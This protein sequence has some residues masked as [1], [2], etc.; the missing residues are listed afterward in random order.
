MGD[1]YYLQTDDN[2]LADG[3]NWQVIIGDGGSTTDLDSTVSQSTTENDLG[4]TTNGIGRTNWDGTFQ[5]VLDVS[6]GDMA[7]DVDVKVGRCNAAGTLQE[8][9]GSDGG[10]QT[11]T[12]AGTYTWN[13]TSLNF[14]TALQTDRLRINLAIENT[15]SMGDKVV[16]FDTN[17]LSWIETPWTS[18]EF[19]CEVGPGQTDYSTFSAW[20]AGVACDL[21]DPV[22]TRVFSGTLTAGTIPDN[23]TVSGEMSLATGTCV[24]VT[25]TQIL[26]DNISAT[27]FE[28]GEKVLND[29]D[30]DQ[31][32][33][34]S[35]AGAP[36]ISVAELANTSTT[37]DTTAVDINWSGGTNDRNYFIAR[38]AS[39]HEATPPYTTSKYH[40]S[41]TGYPLKVNEFGFVEGVQFEGKGGSFYKT[42]R[43]NGAN[44]LNSRSGTVGFSGVLVKGNIGA[45]TSH[46]GIE[47]SFATG[48]HLKG[49]I[50]NS[51]FY[52]F[53]NATCSA[54]EVD[55]NWHAYFSNN[56]IH[57]CT[58]GFFQGGGGSTRSFKNNIFHD[59]S[60]PLED[61]ITVASH[62][63]V[64]ITPDS[65]VAV[66]ST[67]STGATTGTTAS[68]VVDSSATFETDGVQ[69]G[70]IVKNTTDT[71]YTYVT[72]IDSQTQLSVND[73]IFVSGENYSVFTNLYG[74][75]TFENE[76]T[77]DF[78]LGS[79]DTAARG[80][81]TDLSSDADL[82]VTDDIDGD[83]RSAWDVGAD[84]YTASGTSVS[85][86][87][88]GPAP[89]A[90]GTAKAKRKASG[91][92]VGP[93][94]TATGTATRK[95]SVSG[96]GVGPATT[97]SG[98]AKA[99][100]KASG[101]G[102][103]PA[104]T[105]S[106]TVTAAAAKECSGTGIGPAPT[107]SGTVAPRE[108]SV[109]GTGLG[110][111]P[112]ATG[113]AV[114]KVSVTGTGAGPA[115]TASG[116]TTRK[117]SVSGAGIG[118]AP[119]ATGTG[120]HGA[121]SVSGTGIGPA[122]TA[123]GTV[124]PRSIS[125]SGTGVGPTPTAVGAVTGGTPCSGTGVGPAPTATGTAQA[126]RNAAGT[127]AGPAATAS[128][129]A[130]RALSVSGTGVGPAPTAAGTADK[131]MT[132]SGTATGPAPTATG[133]AS[134][135]ALSSGSGT[136]P[137]PTA[138]GTA[139][140][141]VPTT[142]TGIGPAPTASGTAKAKRKAS[143]TGL[144][145]AP[146]AA[147]VVGV[148]Y[149]VDATG[150][151]DGDDGTTEET[152]W[153]T[154]SFLEAQ[155]IPAGATIRLKRGEIWRENLNPTWS[156]SS[157]NPILVEDYGSGDKPSLRGSYIYTSGW[158]D[159][160]GN[161]WRSTASIGTNP[162]VVLH[163]EVLGDRKED[164]VDMVEQWDYWYGTDGGSPA[165]IWIY[166]TAD[167]STMASMIEYGALQHII[168]LQQTDY[169]TYR[170]LDIRQSYRT[171]AGLWGATNIR[172]EDC[173]FRQTAGNCIQFHNGS[174]DGVVT[175]C[176]FDEWNV[177]DT[178]SYAVHVTGLG[179]AD[180]GP[181]DITYCSFTASRAQTPWSASQPPP[182]KDHSCVMGDDGGWVRTF[183]NNTIDG[184]NGNLAR[185]GVTF[186]KPYSSAT[187]YTCEDN[188]IT[189]CG[190]AGINLGQV[191]FNSLASMTIRVRRNIVTDSCLSDGTATAAMR[192]RDVPTDSGWDVEVSY[193]VVNGT[194][195]GNYH[196]GIEL[197]GS[198]DVKVYNNTITGTD[199]GIKLWDTSLN[200]DIQNNISYLNRTY[201][202]NKVSGSTIATC[203][204]NCFSG[205]I[206]ADY[207][208]V[209]PGSKDTTHD[210][211]LDGELKPQVPSTCIDGGTDVGLSQDIIG[212]AV[213]QGSAEDM[214]AYEFRPGEAVSGSGTGPAPTAT[215]TATRTVPVSGT[216]V[217]AAPAAT[218]TVT[219][220][221]EV[222]G[223]GAGASPTATGTATR[224]VSVT[225]TGVGPAPSASGTAVATR[226]CSGA[227]V[228]P[229]PAASGTAT[230]Q[231]SVTGTGVGAAP[232]ATGTIAARALSAS[233][234]G[235]G[236]A[237]TAAGTVLQIVSG[238][239]TAIGPAPTA[240]GT[241]TRTV[242]GSGAGT[243]PA[244][245]ASGVVIHKA[246]A[247]G[248]AV[249]PAPAATGTA[250]RVVSVSGT[251]AGPAPVA[252]GT[253]TRQVSVAGTGV[254]PAP[255][256][257]GWA[258]FQ[259][260]VSGAGVGPAPTAS[261]SVVWFSGQGADHT[262]DSRIEKAVDV[263]SRVG[264]ELTVDSRAV[265]DYEVESPTQE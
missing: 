234:T 142:G 245:A 109:S 150:G 263:D 80:K 122:P 67:H 45:A 152:A 101:T 252:V 74:D 28:S 98:T 85:G 42:L 93:A 46:S 11:V 161:L 148:I 246:L 198:D 258:G 218:G 262:V 173:D 103:G 141:A 64:F 76:G 202:I 49:W 51:V 264:K 195:D 256:A 219:R 33:T 65:T 73:D 48:G 240:S 44:G 87:G 13:F 106:G 41:V 163:D 26:I 123:T 83:T 118:P 68:K 30:T 158:T 206:V 2:G 167:P 99:K 5:V 97:A 35:D 259:G 235:V 113:T 43:P 146:T 53:P 190:G 265:K 56:T 228:G 90:T 92:G 187:S 37:A 38:A 116:T 120:V 203:D 247:S 231:V 40:L 260:R 257:S 248:S 205:N 236:L 78:H 183:S 63:L 86:T 196:S 208:N 105:A 94:P 57:N 134:K 133:T 201:G 188:I 8:E 54:F 104:P 232:T 182:G 112:S 137:A 110:S 179:Y 59:V 223:T 29:A 156:G 81:G 95:V 225:G 55:E 36:A 220:T 111:G 162:Y 165:Y 213:P 31:Y 61:P 210:P 230:R 221:V 184:Q 199:S 121:I 177:R 18:T 22:D 4:I 241:A 140:R 197:D 34:I 12:N 84:E 127:G 243:G 192:V 239:G 132:A 107:A 125:V 250:L 153:Q 244:P 21:T 200:A 254:G 168:G 181:V 237:P 155:S 16:S 136:G 185:D 82:V 170:N 178:L 88:I 108:I 215:G 164:K 10:A 217:G 216:G 261:G 89:T 224:Q 175:G 23:Q 174:N 129:T 176:T 66:G 124:A 27:P 214:G 233:G 62:N 39:G 186:W 204:Y 191:N 222:S 70:S 145:A 131:G 91:T 212:T 249:G 211:N 6:D 9:Y 138:T 17:H 144:G 20:E 15:E 79:G 253:A 157:G 96:T 160:G 72:A 7:I 100:R 3:D 52:D 147:G 255:I 58:L 117:V 25:A 159:K 151:D 50:K 24:H 14:S 114:R 130:T 119:T 19:V 166:S 251:G 128:G 77:D 242:S 102:V 139:T 172:F 207:N 180:S 169:I 47:F 143:G 229:A 154:L 226:S 32:F 171:G 189:D 209:T 193:N 227:G 69:V 75:A 60:S 135:S 1:K 194:Y 126:K 115:A 71:T 238:V 149:Y